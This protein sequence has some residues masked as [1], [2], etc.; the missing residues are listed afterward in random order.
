ML[1]LLLITLHQLYSFSSILFLYNYETLKCIKVTQISSSKIFCLSNNNYTNVFI[2]TFSK[3]T[4]FDTNNLNLNFNGFF[5]QI[6]EK[7]I[8]Y[9]DGFIEELYI[10]NLQ[11]LFQ[12]T[13]Y[14]IFI[15]LLV[16]FI[17]MINYIKKIPYTYI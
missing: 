16:L 10:Y 7:N 8:I 3:L 6:F 9:I 14:C 1:V 17:L 11:I 13:A 15:T 12:H 2:N 4:L 5:K